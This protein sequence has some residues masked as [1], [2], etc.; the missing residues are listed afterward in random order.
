MSCAK[1]HEL[2]RADP[3]RPDCDSSNPQYDGE[4]PRRNNKISPVIAKFLFLAGLFIE[5]KALPIY[6]GLYDQDM[7]F[8]TT[9]AIV[10][11]DAKLKEL[12]SM[13]NMMQKLKF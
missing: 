2:Y 1:C 8:I 12:K 9:L 13:E 3:D 11:S 4:C 6:G 7:R 5:Y 10:G